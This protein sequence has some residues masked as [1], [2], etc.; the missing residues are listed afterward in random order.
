MFRLESLDSFV[1]LQCMRRSLVCS[2]CKLISCGLQGG[3]GIGAGG[4]KLSTKLI[5]TAVVV[6]LQLK[7][8]PV[9]CRF[10]FL[11]GGS[12]LLDLVCEAG[13]GFAFRF[14]EL[15]NLLA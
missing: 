14:V 1:V 7:D 10:T 9:E 2:S 6:L 15:V 3:L 11:F 5:L 12:E 13:L 8:L 4:G